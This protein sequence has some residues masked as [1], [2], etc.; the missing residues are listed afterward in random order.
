MDQRP[1]YS[2][3]GKIFLDTL[4]TPC[5]L[6]ILRSLSRA[7]NGFARTTIATLAGTLDHRGEITNGYRERE[8]DRC[9]ENSKEDPPPC[10]A[11]HERK[12]TSRLNT[13][14]RIYLKT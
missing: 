3:D 10:Q 7:S 1:S 9:K 5:F 13:R 6:V 4:N 14:V 11:R 8:V 2:I 12:R